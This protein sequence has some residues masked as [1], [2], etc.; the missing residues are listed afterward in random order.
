MSAS[1]TKKERQL[2]AANGLSEKEKKALKEAK[3]KKRNHVIYAILGAVAVCCV[4]ALLIWDNGV[5]QKHTTALTVGSERYGVTD[6]EYFYA[7]SYSNYSQYLSLYGLDANSDLTEEEVYEGYTWDQLF[8]D[9]AIASLTNVS[10]LDQEAK[11][12]GY[13]LSEDGQANVQTAVDT[14]STYATLYGTTVDSFLKSNYGKYMT[15]KDYERIYA[16]VV[17]A[18]EYADVKADSF[19]ITDADL[20]AYYAE[21]TADLDTIDFTAYQLTIART[22]T[23]EEGT[24][25]DLDEAA[26]AEN[27]TQAEAQ[28]NEILAALQAG[29]MVEAAELAAIYGASDLSNT[30]YYT[31]YS[32]ADWLNDAANGA[33]ASAVLPNLNSSD[34]P[35]SYTA[36][37]VN[38]RELDEYHGADVR[39]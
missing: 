1:R 23:D 3:A 16:N 21:H 33:G 19:E 22:E 28:A 25:V 6:V 31:S 12:A 8:K 39:V 29:D 26:I 5:I 20:Q 13:T 27:T 24:V 17:L 15:V 36:I 32:F 2:A 9:E 7:N 30:S 10:I 34:E 38:A 35:V 37:L 4:V 14:L 11:A 18:N